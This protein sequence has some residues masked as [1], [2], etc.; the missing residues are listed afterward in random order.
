M[1]STGLGTVQGMAPVAR[2]ITTDTGGDTGRVAF[3][4]TDALG[5]VRAATNTQGEEMV[6][7]DDDTRGYPTHTTGDTKATKFGYAGEYTDP[8]GLDCKDKAGQALVIG[9]RIRRGAERRVEDTV[10]GIPDMAMSMTLTG[11]IKRDIHI[12]RMLIEDGPRDVFNPHVNPLYGLVVDVGYGIN[13]YSTRCWED[14]GHH[15]MG[16]ATSGGHLWPGGA[17]KSPFPRS[18]SGNKI[19]REISDVARDPAT[20]R[21]GGWQGR[22]IVL[23][24]TPAGVD[25]RVVG[26][27]RIGEIFTA[28]PTN[29]PRSP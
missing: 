27:R 28:Y 6:R 3:R 26:G 11:Q 9:F 2:I 21:S 23:T 15:A 20:W 1:G 18:W 12:M 7:F 5:S 16:A 17:G 22:R 29:V 8:T 19:M 10:L 14:L 4:H 24:G 13:A 25:I